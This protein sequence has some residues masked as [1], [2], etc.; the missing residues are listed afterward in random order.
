MEVIISLLLLFVFLTVSA[1]MT[2]KKEL[3]NKNNPTKKIIEPDTYISE[4]ECRNYKI[5][6]D[7]SVK[8]KVSVQEL[9]HEEKKDGD[10]SDIIKDFDIK[11]AIIYK[12]ILE[13][14][15]KQY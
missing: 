12:E 4:P 3:A 14:K 7:Q 9:H 13:P 1:A 8:K 10:V 15:Y 2:I 6:P 11:K 5:I